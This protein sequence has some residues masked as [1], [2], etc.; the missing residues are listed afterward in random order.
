MRC[1]VEAEQDV[2]PE[3]DRDRP[4][5]VVAQRE[6]RDAE[7]RRLLLDAA[8]VGE[9]AGRAGD[10]AQELEVAER[11]EQRAARRGGAEAERLDRGARARMHGEDDGQ[12]RRDAR[13]S[14]AIASASSGP[15]TSAGRCSVTTR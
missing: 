11:L 12:R 13:R 5:G 14:A 15:S 8:R 10:Q 3:L 6:A 2:G 7:V 1:G 9:H 4:L